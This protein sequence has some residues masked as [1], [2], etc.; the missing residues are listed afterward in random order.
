MQAGDTSCL[1]DHVKDSA[2]SSLPFLLH[3][4]LTLLPTCK[5]LG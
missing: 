3:F 2:V 1:P 4:Y 5:N